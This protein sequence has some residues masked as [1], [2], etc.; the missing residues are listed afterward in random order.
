MYDISICRTT[1]PRNHSQT[2]PGRLDNLC[3]I[4]L[5]VYPG[6]MLGWGEW[7]YTVV[8]PRLYIF[9]ICHFNLIFLDGFYAAFKMVTCLLM[10]PHYFF[11]TF[12]PIV[13]NCSITFSGRN[14]AVLWW[15]LPTQNLEPS[16]IRCTYMFKNVKFVFIFSISCIYM[17][18]HKQLS[19]PP[20]HRKKEN[21]KIWRM[22][23]NLEWFWILMHL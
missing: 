2:I 20:K 4:V 19:T 1:G 16:F 17:R 21:K 15:G 11:L 7:S 23:I 5:L 8:A 3:C 14:I 10:A 22:D 13:K 9:P 12:Y 6:W 18:P